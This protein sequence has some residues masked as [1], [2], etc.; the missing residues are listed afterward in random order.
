MSGPAHH[1]GLWIRSYQQAGNTSEKQAEKQAV[2]LVCFPHAGGSAS[3]FYPL[4]RALT[5]AIDVLAVQYPGRQD[6]YREPCV[7]DIHRLADHIYEALLPCL[8]RPFAFFGH[9]MGALLAFEVAR[10]CEAAMTAWP[11]RLFVSG[12]RAP[13]R[14][15]DERVHLADDAGLVRELLT[16]GGTDQRLAAD[17]E[18]LATVLPAVRS[19][20]RAAETYAFTPGPPLTCPITAL[21]GGSDPKASVAEVR[22][23]RAHSAGGFTLRVFP[24]GHFFIEEC[25]DDIVEI[26]T[27]SLCPTSR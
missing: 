19:D 6:R 23:W 24:G 2:R 5:P 11:S 18:L 16:V 17:P 14:H 10:R 1:S 15:R 3:Y 21:T 13:S 25:R 12:R 22:D 27:D 7:D 20:Y 9:S 26:I 4:S 8:D